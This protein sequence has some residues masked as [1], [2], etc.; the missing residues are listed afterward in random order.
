M[1]KLYHTTGHSHHSLKI[2]ILK[3]SRT[4]LGI[5]RKNILNISWTDG[6][7]VR[8]ELKPFIFCIILEW[9]ACEISLR[10][11]KL[12]ARQLRLHLS[13]PLCIN[14]ELCNSSEESHDLVNMQPCFVNAQISTWE[15]SI[16]LLLFQAAWDTIQSFISQGLSF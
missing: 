10:R 7:K 14:E 11:L 2:W 6:T 15:T 4:S 8:W 16:R 3:S 9:I 12:S 5:Q 13:P 1:W